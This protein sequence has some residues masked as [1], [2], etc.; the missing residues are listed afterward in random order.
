MN[1][2]STRISRVLFGDRGR[3]DAKCVVAIKE[4][5]WFLGSIAR[6]MLWVDFQSNHILV[7]RKVILG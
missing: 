1:T 5:W 4:G 2:D 3:K 6:L 7:Q